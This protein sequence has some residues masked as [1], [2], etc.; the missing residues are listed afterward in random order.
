MTAFENA[1]KFFDACETSQGWEGCRQNVVDG[2]TFEAQSEP[3][4][5][6]KSVQA[7]CDWMKAIGN[8]TLPG[9][10]YDVHASAF[11]DSTDTAIFVATF[12]G[13][14]TGEG[15]PVPPTGQETHT[16]YVYALR[17]SGDN[18]V[19][20]MRKVWNASWAMRELGWI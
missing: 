6:I 13:R 3:L 19:A 1:R 20:G 2:A 17:M 11:D 18:K 16:D 8:V 12:H 14:H 5:D 9:A 15:G 10:T 4:A 7:Y